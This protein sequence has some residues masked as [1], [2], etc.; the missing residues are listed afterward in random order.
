[1]KI[2]LHG[3]L[4]DRF[5]HEF[6]IQTDVPADAIEG[7][8]RQL[9]DWPRELR[10]DVL[11]FDTEEKLRAPTDAAEIHLVP[12]MYGG[13][14]KFGQII[15]GA[16]L[17]GAAFIPGLGQIAGVAVSSILFSAGAS[18][19]LTG[20]SQLFMKAPTVDKSSDP[21]ASKYLGN[22]KNTTVIGTLI[23]M[24]WGRIK[25]TGHWL[26]VQVD[27]NDLVTTSFPVTTS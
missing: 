8:S 25:L 21:P 5:G 1:M 22:N 4:A 23:T 2:I 11:D 20:I 7:L 27:S 16:A 24:A 6:E 19:A 26:S 18:M 15:L 10:I 9:P 17:I 14:G 13:G 3:V 12:S